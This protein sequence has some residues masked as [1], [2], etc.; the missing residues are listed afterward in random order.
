MRKQS[1]FL[2]IFLLVCFTAASFSGC[3]KTQDPIIDAQP[4]EIPAFKDFV[5]ELQLDMNSETLKQKVTVKSYVDG[6]T[7]HFYVPESIVSSGILKA[8][9]LGIDTPESTGKI[10]EYGKAASLF[11]KEALLSASSIIIESDDAKWNIDSTGSR[12]LVWVWYRDDESKPYR[13]LNLEILQNGLAVGSSAANNRYGKSCM[14]ALNQAK[15]FKLNVFSGKPDSDYYYGEAVELTIKELR[16]NI[17]DY[18]GIK[19]AFNGIVT[20]C[21]GNGVYIEAYDAEADMYFGIPIYYGFT[22]TGEGLDILSVG[23]EVRVVGTLSYHEDSGTYQ[24]IGVSY[25]V[26]APDDPDN[27]QIIS[28]GN[29]PSFVLTSPETFANGMVT[30]EIGDEQK[31]FDYAELALATSI[32]MKGLTVTDVQTTV[33]EESSSKG[34]MTLTCEADGVI[35]T[36]RTEVLHDE[37]GNIVTADAFMNKTIGIKGIVDCFNGEPQIRVLSMKDISI[38]ENNS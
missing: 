35:I 26:M 8:R 17:E 4:T 16:C 38:T 13:N 33:N 6:D 36:V 1:E 20:K 23:N 28:S 37:N 3:S 27:L 7:T 19:V 5:S 32:E 21:R 10:E 30:L 34:A 2:I 11:T 22:L 18:S 25:R 14:A 31:T 29:E 9:Y 12:Y 15:Q 24:I